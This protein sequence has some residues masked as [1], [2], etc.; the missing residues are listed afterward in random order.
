MEWTSRLADTLQKYTTAENSRRHQV[1]TDML[2]HLPWSVTA[3]DE[4]V[5]PH[6][7]VS[8]ASGAESL[9]GMSLGRDDIDCECLRRLSVRY[10]FITI[11][12][13]LMRWIEALK[14]DPEVLAAIEEG[15][16][17]PIDF[18]Q[19]SV[20]DII[21]NMDMAGGEL[22]KMIERSGWSLNA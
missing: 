3:L 21:S 9:M 18:L 20:D 22:D 12:V 11:L 14:E 7:E 13:A 2:S 10:S 15:D 5:A 16:S 4:S 17:N 19:A 1:K 8:V 6:V